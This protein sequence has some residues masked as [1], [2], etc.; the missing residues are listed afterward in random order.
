M[1]ARGD[2]SSL[3]DEWNDALQ[4]GNPKNV[5]ALYEANAI[6][7]PTVSNKVRHNHEEIEDYFV[8]FL[9]K[10]PQGKID[11]TNVRVFSDIA[12]NSGVYTFSFKDQSSVQARFTFVY[13]WNGQRW[14]IVEHHSSVL[15][16]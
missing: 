4:T 15:P 9:A 8:H 6:L 7:L 11:E 14:M 13:R 5:A 3:F 2:I 12:I 10:G 1:M 16:E